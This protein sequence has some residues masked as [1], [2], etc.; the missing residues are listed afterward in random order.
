[1]DDKVHLEAAVPEQSP[2]VRGFVA[3][4]VE[5][6]EGASCAEIEELPDEFLPLL[7]LSAT[8]GMTRRRGFRGIVSKIKREVAQVAEKN[9]A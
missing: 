5:G 1:V 2:T 9:S 6:L 7:G 4:L 3:L 8:L